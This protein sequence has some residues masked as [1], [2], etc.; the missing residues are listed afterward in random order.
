MLCDTRYY[1]PLDQIGQPKCL[2]QDRDTGSCLYHRD[3]VLQLAFV[4][5]SSQSAIRIICTGLLQSHA[6]KEIANLESC[7][8][9]P[10]AARAR[11]CT[12]LQKRG[13][14]TPLSSPTN[15]KPRQHLRVQLV[16]ATVSKVMRQHASQSRFHGPGIDVSCGLPG[17]AACMN[18]QTDRQHRP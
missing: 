8:M 15:G 4:H 1:H 12:N 14:I 10:E 5:P 13:P 11:S 16:C 18:V 7:K 6:A 3:L 9:T 17:D 2:P